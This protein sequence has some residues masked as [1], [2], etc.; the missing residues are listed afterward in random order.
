MKQ[1]LSLNRERFWPTTKNNPMWLA[2]GTPRS[3][4]ISPN[5]IIPKIYFL[6]RKMKKKE[7]YLN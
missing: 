7:F 1:N 2:C 3:A 4:T 5:N 6:K